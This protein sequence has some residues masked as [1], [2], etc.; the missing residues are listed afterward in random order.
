MNIS[1]YQMWRETL[2]LFLKKNY[3]YTPISHESFAGSFIHFA[4]E[5]TIVGL[6]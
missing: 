3:K 5:I 6:I 1:K 2:L 4:D